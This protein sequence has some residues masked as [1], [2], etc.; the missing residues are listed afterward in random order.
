MNKLKGKA[1]VVTGASKGIGAEIARQMA[2]E[3]ARIVV[4][5]SS[6]KEAAEKV[7]SEII[8]KDG[9]AVAIQAD[10]SNP[11]DIVRLFAEANKALGSVDVLVNNAGIYKFDP[12]EEVSAE[13][14]HRQFNTNVLGPILA[15]KE[16]VKYIG[17]NGG[18][19]INVSS[20]VSAKPMAGSVIYSSTKGAL[21]TATKALALELATRK[22]RVNSIAPGG[23]E[24]EGTHTAG[25][26]GSDFE[27]N[28]VASTPLG[29]MGQP[30]DIAKVAVFLAGDDSG[31][32]TGDKITVAGGY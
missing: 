8:A 13:E 10:M 15:V 9:Q 24:T 5:Y 30:D 1:V 22:I 14:F 3:G 27:K 19:I 7:V 23:I 2:A 31:W 20:V 12:I 25:I 17:P 4:N 6:S 29:R 16:A 11:A 26:M 21:D 32:V 18:S 28:I